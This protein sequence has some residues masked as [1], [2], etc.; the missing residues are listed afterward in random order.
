[1]AGGMTRTSDRASNRSP[2]AGRGLMTLLLGPGVDV[3][4]E[5]MKAERAGSLARGRR[6]ADKGEPIGAGHDL[7]AERSLQ[8]LP[9]DP[10]LAERR[11]GGRD[12]DR[13]SVRANSGRRRDPSLTVTRQQ[14]LG[15][16]ALVIED[17]HPELLPLSVPADALGAAQCDPP[18]DLDVEL[19]EQEVALIRPLAVGIDDPVVALVDPLAEHPFQLP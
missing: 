18:L 9:E 7:A 11:Q 10:V 5:R 4:D 1:M 12:R 6:T 15:E 13:L 3:S 16:A 8:R 2:L 19:P 17:P 14:T